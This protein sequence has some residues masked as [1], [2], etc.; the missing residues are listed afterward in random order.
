MYKLLFW[1][2]KNY[3]G[4]IPIKK[5]RIFLGCSLGVSTASLIYVLFQRVGCYAAPSILF[6]LFLLILTITFWKDK[7]QGEKP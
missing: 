2:D 7:T 4:N 1:L 5:R 3:L 6:T